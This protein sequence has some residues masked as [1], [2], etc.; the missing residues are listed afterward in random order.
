MT[1]IKILH[2]IIR[3]S[4]FYK[5]Y[6]NPMSMS[7]TRRSCATYE[8]KTRITFYS[9]YLLYILI[10]ITPH[11]VPPSLPIPFSSERMEIVPPG[12]PP[13]ALHLPTSSTSGLSASPTKARK[14]RQVRDST[15][16]QQLYG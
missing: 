5:V 10:S 6:K 1:K 15:Y 4:Y 13:S 8:V 7:N 3:I 14:D 11:T 12:Y 16:R 9:H 2:I